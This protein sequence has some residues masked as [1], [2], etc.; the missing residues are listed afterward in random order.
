M[1]TDRSVQFP[2]GT[3][4]SSLVTSSRV[5]AYGSPAAAPSPD[6]VQDKR[7]WWNLFVILM[8]PMISVVDIFIVNVSL[9]TIQSYYGASD[10]KVQLIVAVYLIGY[11]VFLITGSRIGD[12]FG[13]ARI[14][15]PG[16]VLGKNVSPGPTPGNRIVK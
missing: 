15:S 2:E 11:A 6:T 5:Q 13:P 12:K 1:K 8:A 4:P 3:A 9:P 10:A 14:P 16:L 7:R